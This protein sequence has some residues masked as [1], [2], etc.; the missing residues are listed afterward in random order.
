[1]GRERPFALVLDDL[2]WADAGSLELVLHLLRRPPRVPH[3]LVVAL[4]PVDP[5]PV[6]LDALRGVPGADV[7]TLEPLDRTAALELVADV[8]DAGLRERIASE[9]GGNPLFLRELARTAAP[10]EAA[11]PATLLAAVQREIAALPPASRAL[12]DGAAVSGDPFDPELA[13]AASALDPEDVLLPLDRLVAADLV[14]PLEGPRR[15]GFRHPVVRRAV[16]E[17]TPAGWR[18][19][20]HERVAA[21]LERRGAPAGAR[22]YHV[23]QFARPGDAAAD[24][25]AHRGRRRG[26]DVVARI[27]GALVPGGA[28]AA[29]RRCRPDAAGRPSGR[30]RARAGGDRVGWRSAATR[31]SPR[32]T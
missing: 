25:R 24:R 32:S 8:G 11:L 12:L 3:L 16:Y 14:R 22:A 27:G 21:L 4:R 10:G 20:A 1:M 28:G 18:L 13:A 29:G 7:L 9:A 30:A 15:F 19:A 5:L 2:H 31:S 17:A 6:L 26:R 23:E